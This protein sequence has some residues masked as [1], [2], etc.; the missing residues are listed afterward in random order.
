MCDGK[1]RPSI[2]ASKS[3]GPASSTKVGTNSFAA[4][5]VLSGVT[6]P[7]LM[8]IL[9][10]SGLADPSCQ[11]YMLFYYMGPASVSLSFLSSNA[12]MP[13]WSLVLKAG[14]IALWD[15]IAQAMNYTGAALA[16]PTIFAILYSSVTVWTAVFSLIFLKRSMNV[17]Q[18]CG[19]AT[20]FSGLALTAAGSIQLGESV[21]HGSMFITIGS[22]MHGLFY[23]M[24]E[25]VMTKGSEN[26]SV[27]QN[28]AVQG[29]VA[30]FALLL[31][32]LCYTL[33]RSEELLW[34]PM[35]NAGTTMLQGM[36]LLGLFAFVSLI[37]SFSF[38]FTLRNYIGGATSAGVMKGLQAVLVFLVTHITY[39][40]RYGGQ[41][42]C[43]SNLKF[44]SLISVTGGVVIF[45]RATQEKER[46]GPTGCNEGYMRI[47]GHDDDGIEITN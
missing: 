37:H 21:I 26:L 22:M 6:Q 17:L 39:C 40:G 24:S 33:P 7:L 47:R 18:W 20:V 43:F 41:E 9:K 15:L 10:A 1:S 32:Q 11:L 3:P 14:I 25:F 34:D 38:Y 46:T 16:G 36:E 19:V 44:V 42:M 13:P 35:T 8:T 29:M 12:T 28:C 4:I 31:W 2:C 30:T 5:Y 23:V 45:G 27:E